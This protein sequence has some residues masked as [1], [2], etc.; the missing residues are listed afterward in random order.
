MTW[1]NNVEM[2]REEFDLLGKGGGCFETAPFS[3]G[4]PRVLEAAP[5]SG[6]CPFPSGTAPFSGGCP[7]AL[8]AAPFSGGCPFP[9][10]TAPFSGGCP[11]ALEAAPFSGGCPDAVETTPYSS[12]SPGAK[13]IHAFSEQEIYAAAER[14]DCHAILAHGVFALIDG[15]HSRQIVTEHVPVFVFYSNP[16]RNMRLESVKEVLRGDVRKWRDLGVSFGESIRIYLNGGYLQRRK[17]LV[18]LK[19]M[20][21]SEERLTAAR[22]VYGRSYRELEDL[23]SADP[24]AIV[25]GLK[26]PRGSVLRVLTVDGV[27]PCASAGGKYAI[28][29]PLFFMSRPTADGRYFRQLVTNRLALNRTSF[30]SAVQ[31]RSEQAN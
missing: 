30:L 24:G 10:G 28:D 11:E 20:G 8:E 17:F 22:P 7:D 23:A 13:M 21:L 12:G 18:L 16:L 27:R 3:G 14:S 15:F 26:A 1:T 19:N 9:S 29:F 2:D 31:E 4:C 6:G 25:L 5:F